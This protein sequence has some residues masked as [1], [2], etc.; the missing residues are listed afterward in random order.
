MDNLL[1]SL[2]RKFEPETAHD[3]SI[4]LLK[5]APILFNKFRHE[6]LEQE[7]VGLKFQNPVG[8][9]AGYDKNAEV[10]ESLFKIG[11]GFVECGTAVSYTHL[12]LPT[13]RLV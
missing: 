4:K 3:I 12:T 6:L 7:I 5:F 8:M 13:T 2:L 11:F 10:F 1:I 9:A